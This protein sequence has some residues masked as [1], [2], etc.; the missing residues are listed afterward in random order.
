M[1][2]TSILQKFQTSGILPGEVLTSIENDPVFRTDVVAYFRHEKNRTFAIQLLDELIDMR[3]GPSG[4]SGDSLMLACYILGLHNE[5]E[6]CLKIWEAKMVDFD[7]YCYI[8][9]Q[10]VPFAGVDE[11]IAYLQSQVSQE[12]K[13]AVEYLTTCK[14][15]GEFNN[16]DAYFSHDI[17]PWFV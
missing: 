7:T 5:I 16:L 17:L 3:K 10:L 2:I 8:D 14:D 4:V 9:I 12:A 13:M 15:N 6:D 1:N 11:T